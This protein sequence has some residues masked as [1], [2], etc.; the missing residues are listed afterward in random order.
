MAVAF[1]RDIN[2]VVTDLLS[3]EFRRYVISAGEKAAVG[4][5][6]I[7]V[8]IVLLFAVRQHHRCA[9]A[10][11]NGVHIGFRHDKNRFAEDRGAGFPMASDQ[12]NGFAHLDASYV[13]FRVRPIL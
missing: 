10:L 6:D 2:C 9:A 4:H 3:V 1:R 5:A 12:N 8:K 13:I 7:A 11:F